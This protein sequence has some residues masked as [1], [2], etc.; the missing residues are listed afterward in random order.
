MLKVSA[1]PKL[2]KNASGKGLGSHATFRRLCHRGECTL[3]EPMIGGRSRY[4]FSHG[5]QGEATAL[6]VS[7]SVDTGPE[8]TDCKSVDMSAHAATFR[9]P[10]APLAPNAASLVARRSLEKSFGAPTHPTVA[11]P[12]E[13]RWHRNSRVEHRFVEQ[14]GSEAPQCIPNGFGELRQVA[15]GSNVGWARVQAT[16]Q[17]VIGTRP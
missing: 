1:K 5:W 6:C 8:P 12:R 11:P 3:F 13:G 16:S 14:S 15:P 2:P 17:G 7:G 4:D 10:W 9:T